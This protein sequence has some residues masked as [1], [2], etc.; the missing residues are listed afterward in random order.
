MITNLLKIVFTRINLESYTGCPRYYD[1]CN[2][3]CS[4]HYLLLFIRIILRYNND[5]L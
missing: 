1:K 3:F 4:I 2:Y 5:V